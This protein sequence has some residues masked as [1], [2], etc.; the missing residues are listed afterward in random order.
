MRGIR[1]LSSSR[2]LFL[3]QVEFPLGFGFEVGHFQVAAFVDESFEA[4]VV[5]GNAVVE[6]DRNSLVGD[7]LQFGL[8][9]AEFELLGLEGFESGGGGFFGGGAGGGGEFGGEPI[10]F[11]VE[12]DLE[13]EN[14][15]GAEEG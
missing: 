5:V 13:F 8:V 4:G 6:V 3:K 10:D 11:L 12:F 7:G 14:V 15:V 1:V 2:S 9:V